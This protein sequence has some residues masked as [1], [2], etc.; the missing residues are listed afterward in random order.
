MKYLYEIKSRND[1]ADFLSIKHKILTYILYVEGVDN[2]YKSFKIPKKSGGEREI[3]APIDILKYVQKKLER[4]LVGYYELIKDIEGIKT[5]ISHGFE[6]GKSIITNAKIHRNKRYVIN[7]DLENFFGTFHFGRVRGFFEKNRY[8]SLPLDVA[9]ILAQLTCYKG[10]LP[11]GAPTSPI[12]TNLIC[13][14]LDYRILKI[15]KRYKLDYTRYADD[16]TFS[17]NNKHIIENYDDFFDKLK[18][19]IERAGFKINDKK[20]RILY[21][22]SRQEV[23][24]LVVNKKINVSQDYY[25]QT[26]AMAHALYSKGEF[27]IN[28]KVGTI[29]QLEGRFSFIDQLI[30]YNNKIDNQTHTLAALSGREKE[31]KRF[32]FY[33]YFYC[34]KR[35]VVITE[36]KTDSRYL[37]SA[38][39][40]LYQLYP[41]LVKKTYDGRFDFNIS[42]FEITDRVKYFLGLYEGGDNLGNICF[43]FG[44]SKDINKY[45]PYFDFFSKFGKFPQKPI[46]LL[47]DNELNSEKPLKK[48]IYKYAR[49]RNEEMRNN[50]WIKLQDDWNIY[51]LTIDL[52]DNKEE[53]EIEH[54][55]F[56]DVLNIE[57][58]GKTLSL[59]DHYDV[60][61]HYGKEIF[62]KYIMNNYKTINFSRFTNLFNRLNSIV[63]SSQTR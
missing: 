53:C 16:L 36:G 22:D 61:L 45:P 19:E 48:F 31:I 25:R 58:D 30:K 24:G 2:F 21:K 29:D 33:K 47:Y 37:K 9:T 35:P 6:K 43:Y 46:I 28:G 8:F 54:L 42:F 18:N 34:N 1:L 55:F 5:N 57:I 38:L 17:T 12:I 44:K 51:I 4:R 13:Q 63:E 10:A 50:L 7:V 62:S 15:A 49:G 40:S 56:D 14:I 52:V 59:E 26:R 3:C 27:L 41:N 11:Q 32:L 39:K 20:T 23:T 60:S